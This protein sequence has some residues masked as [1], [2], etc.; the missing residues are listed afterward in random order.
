M[1]ETSGGVHRL[2]Q[3]QAAEETSAAPE[4]TET[5]ARL[6]PVYGG[7]IDKPLAGF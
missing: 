3:R 4:A 5:Y 1:Q 6:R 2:Q 7:L